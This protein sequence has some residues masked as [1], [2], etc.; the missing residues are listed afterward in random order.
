MILTCYSC[1]RQLVILASRKKLIEE[2]GWVKTSSSCFCLVCKPVRHL[3][4]EREAME[5]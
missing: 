5:R 3:A 4:L 2:F 1:E